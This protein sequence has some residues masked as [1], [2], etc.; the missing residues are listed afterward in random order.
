[1]KD[2]E[3]SKVTEA[4]PEIDP[5]EG[6]DVWDRAILVE[7]KKDPAITNVAL[8]KMY[9]ASKKTISQRRNKEPFLRAEKAI[10]VP[11]LEILT[12]AAS[13]AALDVVA[14]RRKAMKTR[15]YDA[16][17]RAAAMVIRP[18]VGDKTVVEGEVKTGLTLTDEDAVKLAKKVLDEKGQGKD[19]PKG[20]K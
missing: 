9:K 13:E 5:L 19:K 11:A 1:M 12:N 17:L 6:L 18:I 8:A 2:D 14:I 16:A 20:E 7:I 3:E 10:L 4:P 15:D